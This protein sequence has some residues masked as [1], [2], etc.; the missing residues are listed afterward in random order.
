MNLDVGKL[1]HRVTLLVNQPV[2][3]EDYGELVP[4]WSELCTV[5]GS[6]EPLS[7]K[8]FFAAASIHGEVVARVVIRYRGDVDE[9]MRLTFRGKTYEIIG[10][11]L[12]DKESGL[13]YLTLL[14]K[15]VK[16]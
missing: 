7:T 14:V 8:E 15:E 3:D 4:D 13:E 6:F 11:P 2:Q 10:P 16:A 12:P 1:R 5:W 9:T